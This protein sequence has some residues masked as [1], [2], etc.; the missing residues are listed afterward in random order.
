MTGRRY[1]DGVAHLLERQRDHGSLAVD[2]TEL[3]A[4]VH[5]AA[6]VERPSM[7]RA[8]ELVAVD[9][10]FGEITV[11]MRT[12]PR[13]APE[14]AVETAP[15]DTLVSV[16]F[17]RCDRAGCQGVDAHSVPGRAVDHACEGVEG[18]AERDRAPEHMA[19]QRRVRA[20]AAR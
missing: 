9:V 20:I 16:D 7:P 17:D 11:E 5:V 19:Q 2:A 6:T 1:F 14:P 15:H 3:V 18:R 4:F 10:A 12:E 13:R 8:H